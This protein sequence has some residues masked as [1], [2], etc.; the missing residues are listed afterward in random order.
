MTK[1]SITTLSITTILLAGCHVGPKYVAPVTPA[2][3]AFKESAPA[4]YSGTLPGTWAPANPQ[5][6]ALK[7]KWWEVFN[8]P[9]LNQLEE[10]LNIDNQNIAVYF[11]N[12]MAARAAVSVARA[13]LFPT[14]TAGPSFNRS[15]TPSTLRN[16]GTSTSTTSGTTNSTFEIPATVSWAPDLWGRIASQIHEQ[17]YAAQV[18]AADLENERLTEQATLAEYYFNLR[19]QDSL[20]T[21]YNNVVDADQKIVDLTKT[22]YDTGIDDESSLVAAQATLDAAKETAAGIATNRALYEHAIATLIG[23]PASTF[24]LPVKPLTTPIPAIPVGLPS[25]L[26]QRRPDIA[27]AERTLAEQNALIDYGIASFYPSLTLTGSGGIESALISKLFTAPALFWS[28]AASSS[29]ILYE[30]G[31]R[32]AAV[33]EYTAQY[34]A[35]LASYKQTVLTAF[36]QVEDYIS[37]LRVTS[38]QSLLEEKAV[39]SAQHALDLETARYQTGIDPYIN[40]LSAQT[41]LF[42]DQATQISLHTSQMTAAI[43]LIQALGGGWNATQLPAAAT[44]ATAPPPAP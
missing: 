3:P 5:D 37:T 15:R 9:E 43:E 16:T 14:V 1:S 30:G 40:V 29:Q 33:S 21:F 42:S 22:L 6:A 39:Q 35:N 2:P 31:A 34:N 28:A 4:A 38:N 24:S 10:K 20:Q 44:I 27:A 13:G 26:L 32:K 11:Q 17:Q 23:Q 18:S 25:E 7:G 36:Q 19:G 41:T 8:E 12:F